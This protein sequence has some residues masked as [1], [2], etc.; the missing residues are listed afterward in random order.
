[1]L[2]IQGTSL[3]NEQKVIDADQRPYNDVRDELYKMINM[4]NGDEMAHTPEELT[5]FITSQKHLTEDERIKL[6]MMIPAAK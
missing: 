2:D 6:G 5:K 3:N 1:M 4:K